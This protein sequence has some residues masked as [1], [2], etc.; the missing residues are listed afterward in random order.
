MLSWY[1]IWTIEQ[2]ICENCPHCSN[3]KSFGFVLT[4]ESPVCFTVCVIFKDNPNANEEFIRINRAY[5]I[6]KDD[7]LRKKYDMYGE[8]GLKDNQNQGHSYQSWNF[9]KQNFGIYDDDPEIQTLSRAD[10]CKWKKK[11]HI[12]VPY[13]FYCVI[14]FILVCC[15]LVQAVDSTETIW[16][17]NFYSTQCS[18]C[19]ELAPTVCFFFLSFYILFLIFPI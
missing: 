2:M 3:W 1:S 11:L 10:F 4:F 16:F 9:Y 8:D 5:E 14:L 6:L 18:H 17:I 7:D 19:H 12:T 13:T 15:C